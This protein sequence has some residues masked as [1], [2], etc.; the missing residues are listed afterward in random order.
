[1]NIVHIAWRGS[2]NYG[3]DVMAEAIKIFLWQK[4]KEYNYWV[5]AEERPHGDKWIYPFKIKICFLRKWWENRILRKTDLLIIG[6]GSV[7]HSAN[8]S[9]WKRRGAEYLKKNN[10]NGRVVG[11]G[12][13]I[14]PFG[15]QEDERACVKLLQILDTCSF[16]DEDSFKFAQ[17]LNLP[18]KPILSFDLAASYLKFKN[19]CPRNKVRTIN[20]IGIA[21]RLPYKSNYTKVFNNYV[22][23]LRE[24]GKKYEKIK[25][26]CFSNDEQ[27]IELNF[28]QKLYKEISLDNL[29]IIPY[30]NDSKSFTEEIKRC[31]FFISTKLHGIV[32]PFLLD[33]PFIS[34]SYQKKFEDFCDYINLP[35]QY[36]FLQSD[37]E[38]ELILKNISLYSLGTTNKF[39]P[40][41]MKNFEVFN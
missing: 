32:V 37:F 34:I 18:Y 30:V 16:R 11:V 35:L 7:L 10:K 28:C 2:K 40:L 21:V 15:S 20:N 17:K 12:L 22:E 19:I 23:L 26:F 5:W 8:S 25:L 27:K 38:P 1:M 29:E 39:F 36:R 41:A 3:D 13:S 24:L 33:V 31:D 14:G 9:N 4:Y 6:G